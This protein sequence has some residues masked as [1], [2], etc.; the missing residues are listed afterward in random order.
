MP[1]RRR[2]QQERRNETQAAVLDSACFL[3][4]KKGYANTSLEEIALDCGVT[5]SPIYHY[6][7]NKKML[8]T[9]AT[10]VLELKLA[11]AIREAVKNSDQP[12]ILT[13]WSKFIE[14]CADAGFRQVVLIDAPNI[15]GRER[16]PKCSAFIEIRQLLL[17]YKPVSALTDT[18]VE[19][20]LIARMLMSALA[21]AAIMIGESGAP[22]KVGKQAFHLIH[23]LV[24]QESTKL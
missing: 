11:L 16:W 4:G 12:I 18:A 1:K 10:E 20:E 22:K 5:T 19:T 7:K 13:I 9:A 15:L 8:F 24:Q 2:T 3:F 6:Y 14:I 17:T 21:E 23:R